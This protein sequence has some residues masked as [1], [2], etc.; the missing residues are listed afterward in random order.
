MGINEGRQIQYNSLLVYHQQ[1]GLRKLLCPFRA[2]V[3][4]KIERLEVGRMV[5][6]LCVICISEQPH[7]KMSS[8]AYHHSNFDIP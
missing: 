6:I 8:C 7:F 2:I 3:I 5:V 1:L 4:R